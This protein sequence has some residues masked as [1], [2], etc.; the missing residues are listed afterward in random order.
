M[1]EHCH[2]YD[3]RSG[4]VE[5]LQPF[6]ADRVLEIAKARD[7]AAR[8]CQTRHETCAERIGDAY[9]HNRNLARE[10]LQGFENGSTVRHDGIQVS[11]DEIRSFGSNAIGSC[12]G[13][14]G[15]DFDILSFCPSHSGKLRAEGPYAA[16]LVWIGFVAQHQHANAPHPLRLLRT[17]CE[18]PSGRR[19]TEEPDELAA[20]HGEYGASLL[21]P[22]P[23]VLA[24]CRRYCGGFKPER[25]PTEA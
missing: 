22:P 1:Q 21:P 18:R 11:R 16:L 23:G 5:K 4:F 3:V 10:L 2:P 12:G 25:V 17:R 19:A 9:E 13:K 8:P 15:V 6:S 24:G 7:V 20:L 14:L